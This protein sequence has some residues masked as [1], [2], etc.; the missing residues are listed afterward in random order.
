ML[1]VV[2]LVPLARGIRVLV[3]KILKDLGIIPA[4]AGNTVFMVASS[5]MPGELPPLA[6]GMLSHAH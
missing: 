2:D 4:C 5:I 6:R 1:D 3:G